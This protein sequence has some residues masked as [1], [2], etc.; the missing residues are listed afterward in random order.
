MK[1]TFVS[2]TEALDY[3]YAEMLKQ[4]KSYNTVEGRKFLSSL[5]RE[6]TPAQ[7]ADM[8]P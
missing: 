4:F 5:H 8:T 2:P 6:R 7:Q 1:N 3:E